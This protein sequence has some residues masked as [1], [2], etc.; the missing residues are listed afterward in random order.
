MEKILITGANGF[1]GTAL[2]EF[3]VRN[4][5]AVIGWNRSESV[6][7]CAVDMMNKNL[8]VSALEKERPDYIFHCAG[9]A[10]VTKSV[11]DPVMDYESNVS[12]TQYL[13][14]AVYEINNYNPRI[15]FLSSAGVYGNPVTLPIK[16]SDSYNPLSPYALHKVMCEQLCNFYYKQYRLDIKIARIFSAYGRG[17]KKQIFWDMN[18][19]FHET[20]RLDMFGTGEESRDYIYISDLVRALNLISRSDEKEIVYNVANGVETTIRTITEEFA[21]AKGI[22]KSEILFNGDVREGDPFNWRADITNISRLGYYPTVQI[23]D[24][25]A[26]YVAWLTEIESSEV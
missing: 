7:C 17:L 13:L 19:K 15:V 8:I 20:G 4:G 3:Y 25:I 16:E 10:D 5:S 2:Y 6:R 9:S 22:D 26:D 12:I 14:Q 23:S 21:L 1:I 11:S 18:R 24:G